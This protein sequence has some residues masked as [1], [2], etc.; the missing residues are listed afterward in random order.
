[1]DNNFFGEIEDF[2]ESF[3][4]PGSNSS[5]LPPPTPNMNTNTKA[6]LGERLKSRNGAEKRKLEEETTSLGSPGFGEITKNAKLDDSSSELCSEQELPRAPNRS[7]TL[8]A[9][10]LTEKR[11]ISNP[12]NNSILDP[13]SGALTKDDHH[14][15]DDEHIVNKAGPPSRAKGNEEMRNYIKPNPNVNRLL[16]HLQS[17]KPGPKK[18]ANKMDLMG[19]ANNLNNNFYNNSESGFPPPLPHSVPFDPQLA[20][21][22]GSPKDSLEFSPFD[23]SQQQ[24]LVPPMMMRPNGMYNNPPNKPHPSSRRHMNINNNPLPCFNSGNNSSVV[25]PTPQ[26]N[27]IYPQQHDM[28]WDYS[29]NSNNTV[30]A[31]KIMYSQQQPQMR[32]MMMRQDFNN[33]PQMNVQF[34]NEFGINPRG[35]N[36]S[37]NSNNV[38]NN[39]PPNRGGSNMIPGGSNMYRRMAPYNNVGPYG[40]NNTPPNMLMHQQYPPENFNNYN[41]LDE[42]RIMNNN[43]PGGDFNTGGGL[44]LQ[45]QGP[46]L[47]SQRMNYGSMIPPPNGSP[48]M[49]S[50]GNVRFDQQQPSQQFEYNG[51]RFGNRYP[52]YSLNNPGNATTANNFQPQRSPYSRPPMQ[53][54]SPLPPQLPPPPPP[55]QQQ[56]N[57][58]PTFLPGEEPFSDSSA[59]LPI[60]NH[61]Q[62]QTLH[63]HHHQAHHPH[64]PQQPLPPPTQQQQPPLQTDFEYSSWKNDASEIRKSLLDNLQKALGQEDSN[65]AY[66]AE[67]VESEAFKASES[68]EAYYQR[69]AEWLAGIFSQQQVQQQ[70]QDDYHQSASVSSNGPT[71]NNCPNSSSSPSTQNSNSIPD[72]TNTWTDPPAPDV[73]STELID[74]VLGLDS[75]DKGNKGN[76]NGSGTDGTANTSANNNSTSGTKSVGSSSSDS[77]SEVRDNNSGSSVVGN[78]NS[79][80]SQ[81]HPILSS[82][83]PAPPSSSSTS[84]KSV[85][86]E[87]FS[88]SNSSPSLENG[89]NA[90]VTSDSFQSPLSLSSTFSSTS[91]TTT[92][93]PIS[94]TTNKRHTSGMGLAS[95]GG[96]NGS[97]V[98][99]NPN[100][101]SV[102]AAPVIA[103]ANTNTTN[104]VN[105]P[106][107]V[108]SGIGSP[109]S[110]TSS[111]LYSPKIPQGTSPSLIPNSENS[112]DK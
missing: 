22:I 87:L 52:E 59:D 31:N 40:N 107:S 4:S 51:N 103:V 91:T 53:Q 36:A 67:Q 60:M 98:N 55:P 83:L 110:I 29:N 72:S 37:G 82:L 14:L 56:Q 97:N 84:S 99:P 108:D 63:P 18:G 66:I 79:S 75:S 13:V 68:I 48:R 96:G 50:P 95:S 81:V 43:C 34:P 92:T 85:V 90:V 5:P 102:T 62:P 8:L 23:P 20:S 88:S 39:F 9:Q 112:P 106:H 47:P 30:G 111:S 74:G 17:N 35:F 2:L 46:H 45:S 69:L 3:G 70:P 26:Q 71:S 12:S 89:A 58:F 38:G 21:P 42:G 61:S 86:D 77:S 101:N 57:G 94:T 54:N 24:Q 11:P 104:V 19:P 80:K 65:T 25:H 16:T 15:Y 7:T 93:A 44:P 78:S 100:S 10:A 41:V 27:G 6:A 109:R 73:S 32:P 1:M 33:R 76:N 64:H 49:N 105:N 28:N